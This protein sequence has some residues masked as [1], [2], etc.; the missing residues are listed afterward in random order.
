MIAPQSESVVTT[1][2]PADLFVVNRL[3]ESTRIPNSQ[4]IS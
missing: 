3:N 1:F 2:S 4:N